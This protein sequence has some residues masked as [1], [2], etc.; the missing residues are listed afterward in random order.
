MTFAETLRA[1]ELAAFA[2]NESRWYD[3]DEQPELAGRWAAHCLNWLHYAVDHGRFLTPELAR[4]TMNRYA[5]HALARP[6]RQRIRKV[7]NHVR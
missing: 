1:C 5:T 6:P 2:L 7:T 4:D 3:F